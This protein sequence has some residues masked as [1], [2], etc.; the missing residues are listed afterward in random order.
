MGATGLECDVRES[1]DG[2]PIIFHDADL[3]R[4]AGRPDKINTLTYAQIRKINAGAGEKIPTLASVIKQTPQ[5]FLLN[6]EIK[7]IRPRLLL[8]SIYQHQAI[9]R[10]VVSSFNA[11][12]LFQVRSLDS[13]IRI[14]YLVDKEVK[15]STIEKANKMGAFA[16]HLSWRLLTNRLVAQVHREGFLL[17]SYTVDDEAQMTRFIEMGVD[18]LFTNR[19]DRLFN[20][21]DKKKC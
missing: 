12:A 21:Q 16:L 20:L 7:A 6:L 17:Y 15:P 1:L 14:G 10:V 2:V 13:T 18:G 3:S 4:I 9:E 11:R 8:E 5:N 19:P